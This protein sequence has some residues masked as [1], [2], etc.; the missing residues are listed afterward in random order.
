MK[1]YEE[2]AQSALARGKAMRTQRQKTKKRL[3]GLLATTTATLLVILLITTLGGPS[4]APSPAPTAPIQLENPSPTAPVPT[5]P[6]LEPTIPP[7]DPDPIVP[8]TEPPAEPTGPQT[9][10]PTSLRFDSIE[11]LKELL[12]LA[13]DGQE[14]LD[15]WFSKN[16]VNHET[17][18]FYS[19]EKIKEFRALL[20]S[21]TLPCREDTNLSFYALYYFRSGNIDLFYDVNGI[22]YLFSLNPEP[23]WAP[24]GETATPVT[25]DG[26]TAELR[27]GSLSSDRRLFATFYVGDQVISMWANTTNPAQVDFSGFYWGNILTDTP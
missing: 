13:D 6:V 3:M 17:Q 25:L 24:D 4:D 19:P 10:Q 12:D 21:I 11:E 18:R 5:K 14:A 22:R 15:D 23:L 8:G 16:R 7:V 2:M 26:V 20:N 27:E 9:M 1:T